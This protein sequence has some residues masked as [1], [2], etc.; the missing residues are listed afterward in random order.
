VKY[1]RSILKSFL[2][3]MTISSKK[4]SPLRNLARKQIKIKRRE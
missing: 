2:L 1:A 4:S 3:A